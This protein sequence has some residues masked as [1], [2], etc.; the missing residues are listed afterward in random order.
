MVKYH[1]YLLCDAQGNMRF[2]KTSGGE[3]TKEIPVEVRFELPSTLFVKPTIKLNIGVDP[4]GTVEVS[5]EMREKTRLQLEKDLGVKVEIEYKDLK[6]CPTCNGTG[7]GGVDAGGA[8]TPCPNCG[9]WGS[10]K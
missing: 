3:G 10:L 8:L 5:P 7:N 6:K 2:R 1:G 9:G 4:T